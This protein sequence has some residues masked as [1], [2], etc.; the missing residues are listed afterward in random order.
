L[1]SEQQPE[2]D[3]FRL[4]VFT[5]DRSDVLLLAERAGF[6]LPRVEIPR[7]ERA[8]EK[9]TAA[10][11]NKYGCG[12]ICLLAPAMTASADRDNRCHYQAMECVCCDENY[13]DAVWTSVRSLTLD[14]FQDR[15]DYQALERCVVECG[16]GEDNPKA[17]FARQGWFVG[18]RGWITDTIAPLALQL[19]GPFRQLNAS[20]SFS[21][22]RF[23]TNGPAVWFKAVG[24]TNQREF[25]ITLELA[26]LFPEYVPRI[27][28][29]KHAWNGWLTLEAPGI[30]L[31]ET[32][33]ITDWKDA[34][35]ALARLQAESVG[36]IAPIAEAGAHHVGISELAG[37]VDPFLE[38][39][40]ELMKRQAK[41]SPPPLTQEELAL[42]G[43]RI[44]DSLTLLD[45]LGIPDA[46]GHFDLN[47]WNIIVSE[48]RSIFLDWAEAY[49]GHPLF[50]LEYLLEHFRRV[51]GG[52]VQLESQLIASYTNPWMQFI[53]ATVIVEARQHTPLLAAFTY[54]TGTVEWRDAQKLQ[55]TPVAGFLRSLARR[56][57]KEA[58]H[59]G[60]LRVSCLS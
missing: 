50:S 38:V 25:P 12:A 48:R 3:S 45:L 34:A 6:T 7:W 9:L 10:T 15:A 58:M 26:H 27:I 36:R 52:D 29:T 57:N 8:A 59:L 44:K 1:E 54:A 22:I 30:N 47:P 17:T 41:V 11:R 14:S 60:E 33:K 39:I 53:P 35:L 51:N 46:L 16:S 31:G 23:E 32:K 21:L 18:L 2:H 5:Q 20:P 49:V 56:M 55:D 40:A 42:L 37:L 28:G 24:E 13:T 19:S 43:I 4:I